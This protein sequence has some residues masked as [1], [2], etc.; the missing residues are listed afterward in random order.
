MVGYEGGA[1]IFIDTG[2]E[3]EKQLEQPLFISKMSDEFDKK[4]PNANIPLDDLEL[5]LQSMDPE[6]TAIYEESKEEQ[7]YETQEPIG[8]P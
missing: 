1:L 7:T 8:L 6:D 4:D 2:V 3:D 5:P